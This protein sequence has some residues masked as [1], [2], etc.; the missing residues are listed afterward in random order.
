MLGMF[1]LLLYVIIRG[2]SWFIGGKVVNNF[3]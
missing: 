2:K 3:W 1:L